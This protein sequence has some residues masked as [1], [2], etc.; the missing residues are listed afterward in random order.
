MTGSGVF[1]PAVFT[2]APVSHIPYTFHVGH[3]LETAGEMAQRVTAG[4]R[5]PVP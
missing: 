3:T 4:R 1:S 2:S 5:W